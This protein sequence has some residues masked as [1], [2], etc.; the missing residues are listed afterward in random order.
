[1]ILLVEDEPSIAALER[2]ALERAGFEVEEVRLGAHALEYLATEVRIA[3]LVL[4]YRL[5]DMTGG[6]VV[7]A[8]GER[9]TSLPVVVVTGYPDPAVE[10][11]MRAAGVYDYL[12]KDA[13]LMFLDDLPRV[14]RSALPDR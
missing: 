1:M 11:W 10:S 14:V 12:V 2:E 13:D 9:I 5:P 4:D 3:L 8:L 7:S 6:D